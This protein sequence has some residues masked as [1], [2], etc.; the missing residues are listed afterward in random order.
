VAP[1]ARSLKFSIG[2]ATPH[3]PNASRRA[4]PS[5]RCAERGNLI[6]LTKADR[7][8]QSHRSKAKP[9]RIV[10]PAAVCRS[11]VVASARCRSRRIEL[12]PRVLDHWNGLELDIGELAVDLFEPA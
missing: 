12:R 8:R 7:D 6:S 9:P 4:P 3:P 1:Q 5:P 2:C 11:R 10:G